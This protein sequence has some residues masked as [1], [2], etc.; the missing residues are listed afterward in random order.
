MYSYSG[1]EGRGDYVPGTCG[2]SVYHGQIHQ[3]DIQETIL[4]THSFGPVLRKRYI[5][6]AS[7]LDDLINTPPTFGKT[8]G[9]VSNS[10]DPDEMPRSKLFAKLA[11]HSDE[12][13]RYR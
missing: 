6:S 12:N 3:S 11:P 1:G 10:L 5:L 7:V 8:I 9:R 13:F 4:L 2:L